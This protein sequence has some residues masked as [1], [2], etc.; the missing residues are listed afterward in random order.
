MAINVVQRGR[1]GRILIVDQRD[2]GT[3]VV[4]TCEPLDV[5]APGTVEQAQSPSGA[6][7]E[8]YKGTF[9]MLLQRMQQDEPLSI[10]VD[11]TDLPGKLVR[12]KSDKFISSAMRAAEAG[13]EEV[14]LDPAE[15]EAWGMADADAS[16]SAGA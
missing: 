7:D 11:T 15:A 4:L 16:A 6:D 12:F 5:D 9:P 14:R 8:K 3:T 13:V 1:L 2:D 10:R